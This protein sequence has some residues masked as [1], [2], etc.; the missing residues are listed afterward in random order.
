[1][2]G[3][4]LDLNLLETQTVSLFVEISEAG[5]F[6][7]LIFL[8][9]RA[10]EIRDVLC[11]L[12][13]DLCLELTL[14]L[15]RPQLRLEAIGAALRRVEAAIWEVSVKLPLFGGR[16]RLQPIM[17]GIRRVCQNSLLRGLNGMP[18]HGV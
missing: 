5:S 12:L 15:T 10:L 8:R 1:M 7:L 13:Q 6:P 2:Q 18:R 4:L 17:Y 9:V 3:S 16:R 14:R 11:H